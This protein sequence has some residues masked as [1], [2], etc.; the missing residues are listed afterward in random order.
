VLRTVDEELDR[1]ATGGLK[2][3]EL[4]RT[5]ARMATHLL[6]ETDS[7]LGRAL[8]MAALEQQRGRPEMLNDLPRLVGEVTDAQIVAAAATLRPERRATIEL[9]PGAAQ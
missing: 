6:R 7:V 3:G 9:I 1:L 2:P 8:P 4:A 5:Q